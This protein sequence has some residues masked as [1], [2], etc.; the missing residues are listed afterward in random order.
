MVTQILIR[1]HLHPF[2][3]PEVL[4]FVPAETIIMGSHITICVYKYLLFIILDGLCPIKS[5]S[6]DKIF[7]VAYE[8][9]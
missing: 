7:W 9:K 3:S 5:I 2:Q 1:F 4:Q 8:K 6:Y